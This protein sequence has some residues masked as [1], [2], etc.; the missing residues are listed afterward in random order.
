MKSLSRVRRFAT[1]WTVACTR[2]LLHQ[3]SPSLGF[4][5]QEYWSGLPFPSPGNLPTQGSNPG[6]PHC[7]Q[8]LYHLSHQGSPKKKTTHKKKKKQ[9]TN[10]CVEGWLAI[11]SSEG[12]AL[13]RTKP[14][15]RSSSSMNDLA[16]G[17]PRMCGA[18]RARIWLL[19]KSKE[20]V[21]MPESYISTSSTVAADG[22]SFHPYHFL[23]E[24][25]FPKLCFL[26]S[27]EIWLN[28][29]RDSCPWFVT[30]HH[31]WRPWK[32]SQGK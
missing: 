18:W 3:A 12:A 16:P 29:E 5:R 32:H 8:T 19:H 9:K 31:L 17:S 26:F 10:P 2:F 4:S 20:A 30:A 14:R 24:F 7:R 1:P 25:S 27:Y 6:L 11:Y 22:I 23:W 13:L 15:P 21:T 28:M